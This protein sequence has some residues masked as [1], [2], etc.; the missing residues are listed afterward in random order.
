M[1]APSRE[2]FEELVGEALDDVPPQM[3]EM[4]DNVAFFVEDEPEP[5]QGE[6]FGLYE[7]TPLTA[8]Y[9]DWGTPR[10][11]DRIVLFRGTLSRHCADVAELRREI[12]VTLVHEM[13]HHLG[14][15]EDRLHELGW[16]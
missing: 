5:D 12:T 2:Q 10:M 15:E 11:P 4:L 14:I 9:A 7:G 3:L 16:G 8:R 6:L 13:A 1:K